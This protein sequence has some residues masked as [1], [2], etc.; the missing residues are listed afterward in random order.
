MLQSTG[1]APSSGHEM[2]ANGTD[3]SMAAGCFESGSWAGD[4]P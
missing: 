4:L 1:H 2:K 3:P